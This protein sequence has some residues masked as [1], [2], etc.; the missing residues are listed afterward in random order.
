M[1]ALSDIKLERG[2][3]RGRYSATIGDGEPAELTFVERGAGHIVIDHTYVP[4][5]YRGRGVALK[6]LTKAVEDARAEG[7]KITPVCSYAV[8]EFRNRP[9]WADVL[10]R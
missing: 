4:A 3:G 5:Q 7:T 10:R 1:D 6:L 2:A 8:A 9:E